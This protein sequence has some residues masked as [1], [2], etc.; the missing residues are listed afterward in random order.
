MNMG[1]EGGGE[2]SSKMKYYPSHNTLP[3][4]FLMSAI[5]NFIFFIAK[6]HMTQLGVIRQHRR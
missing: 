1:E 2:S 6:G 4:S 3:H 5:D